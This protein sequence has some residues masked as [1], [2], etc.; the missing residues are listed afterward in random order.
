MDHAG[1]K[2][3]EARERLNLTYRDIEEATRQIASAKLNPEYVVTISRLSDI[4][5]NDV[6]PTVYRMYSLCVVYR[7]NYVD[8]LRWYGVDLSNYHDDMHLFSLEKT[9][10]IADADVGQDVQLP[11]RLDPGF[12]LR[13][14]SYLSRMIQ[15]WG[16][17]PVAMLRQLDVRNYRYGYIGMDDWVMYPLVTPGAMVQIDTDRRKIET[18][19][20]NNEF[21]RPIYFLETRHS[22]VCSW[23]TPM[24]AGQLL[25]QPYPLSPCKATIT[26]VP[27]EA[28]VVGLVT[29]VA[30]QL[31]VG[32][33]AKARE[34]SALR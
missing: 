11:I 12:N 4:E 16:T 28:N 33:T 34:S 19:G 13:Q 21:E 7:L 3:R 18:S 6:L 22:Y 14:T 31:T 27:A 20:W 2:F 5:N 26:R 29:G 25:L 17:V 8:V 24:G 15:G 30:M 1:W 32:M 9:H 23:V 10:L